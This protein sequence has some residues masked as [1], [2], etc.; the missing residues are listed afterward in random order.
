MVGKVVQVLY[1]G[2]DEEGPG[3]WRIPCGFVWGAHIFSSGQE[4]GEEE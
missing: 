4:R 1:R 2:D 3:V